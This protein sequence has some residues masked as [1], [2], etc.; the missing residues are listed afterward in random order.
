MKKIIIVTFLLIG[1]GLVQAAD[2]VRDVWLSDEKGC[3]FYSRFKKQL[4]SIEWA[5]ACKDGYL[6]GAGVVK[7]F[8]NGIHKSTYS[9][10]FEQG[11]LMGKGVVEH[12]NSHTHDVRLEAVFFNNL[13]HG[14]GIQSDADGRRFEGN[15]DKGCP[16]AGVTSWPNGVRY[17]GEY[18]NCHLPAE[19]ASLASVTLDSKISYYPASLLRY[20]SQGVVVVAMDVTENNQLKNLYVTQSNH[21]L[22]EQAT[23]RSLRQATVKAALVK[24]QPVQT[25][26]VH[27]ASFIVNNAGEALP[28]RNPYPAKASP[29]EPELLQYDTPPADKLVAPLVYPLELLK[30]HVRGTAT[31]SVVIDP[32][33]APQQLQIVESSEPAFGQALKAMLASSTFFPARKNKQ[34]S[35]SAFNIK[36]IFTQHGTHD[37]AINEHGL[38]ILDELR[39][40]QPDIA[41]VT[42]LDHAPKPFYTPPPVY[43]AELADKGVKGT[44]LVEFYIDKEGTVQFPHALK[45]DNEELTWLALTAVAR[46]QFYPPLVKGAAVDTVVTVPVAFNLNN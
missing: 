6:D 35:W 38:R 46:W 24:G 27:P 21:P 34:F 37:I 43:P 4:D 33:G 30:Q 9:G 26:F 45:S 13:P 14:P 22:F 42:S 12:F 16:Q 31:V 19:V 36:R 39:G 28:S 5:G 2:A 23:I 18:K 15:F 32:A 29:Q 8:E 11:K 20:G 25:P 17:E 10:Q 7:V 41:P 44:V 1:A 40:S 3:K